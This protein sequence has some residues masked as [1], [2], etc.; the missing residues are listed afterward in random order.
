MRKKA[1]P[2]AKQPRRQEKDL[3]I[4][5]NEKP[6][7]N[8]FDEAKSIVVSWDSLRAKSVSNLGKPSDLVNKRYLNASHRQD[9]SQGTN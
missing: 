1:L 8:L 2:D 4:Y 6:Q 3:F 5:K 7:N 9:R